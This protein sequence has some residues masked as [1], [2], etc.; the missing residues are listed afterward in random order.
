LI[1]STFEGS[2]V[3]ILSDLNGNFVADIVKEVQPE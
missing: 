2:C 1:V 3:G